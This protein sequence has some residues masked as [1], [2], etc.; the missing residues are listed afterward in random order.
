MRIVPAL[1]L[2]IASPA[3]TVWAQSPTSTPRPKITGISHVA[4]YSDDR[5][6]SRRFYG[7]MLGLT[8]DTTR[9]DVDLYRI[10]RQ[11]IE[12]EPAVH[13]GDP[14][15]IAHYAFA[16]SDAEAL[17]RYLDEHGIKV[18][19]HVEQSGTNRWF[20]L[21]D[22]EDNPIEF[23]EES[24]TLA[25]DGV[26]RHI[27]HAGFIVRDRAREDSFYR[28]VLG[29]RV[30]WQGGMKDGITDFVDMQVPDG[31]DW[32]EYMLNQ[33]ANPDKHNLGV[34]DHVALGVTDIE[35]TAEFLRKRGWKASENEK[36]KI[37]RDGKWQI[38]LYDPDL[39]RVELMT[40]R[41]VQKPCCSEYLTE[42]PSEVH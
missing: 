7:E 39:T 21:R 14:H 6:G 10:G 23:V 22:P 15:R 29:F 25:L 9:T 31:N 41:P 16:T 3:L 13:P 11:S 8:R 4:F 38:N 24:S 1:V 34:Q 2:L 5:E 36:Q 30:Y 40:F 35:T 33:P 27:I 37:G 19:L 12:I 18:P 17:R 32:L 20:A 26:S 42:H 28:D